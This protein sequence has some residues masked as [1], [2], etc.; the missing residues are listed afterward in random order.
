[1]E[2]GVSGL[3]RPRQNPRFTETDEGACL[4]RRDEGAYRA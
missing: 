2:T 1:M 4:T 3:G